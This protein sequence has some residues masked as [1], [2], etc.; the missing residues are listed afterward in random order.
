[1]VSSK[2]EK[3]SPGH[4][5]RAAR[6]SFLAAFFLLGLLACNALV[7]IDPPNRIDDTEG[8][9]TGGTEGGESCL[10]P[11]DCVD[12]G[13]NYVCLFR[14]CSPPCI[15]DVDCTSGFRC[16]K[17]E[18]GN[19]CVNAEQAACRV[20]D[21]AS[22]CPEGNVCSGGQCRID[23][24]E[25]E[26]A[27][28]TGQICTS[29][30]ICRG[31]DPDHDP[32]SG[33]GTTGEPCDAEG[34][35]ACEDFASTSR[36]ICENEVWTEHEPCEAG[37]FCNNASDP[38]GQCDEILAEC[39]GKQPIVPF[40]VENVRH[41]C[42][43]DLVTVE[44]VE[45]ESNQHCS[46]GSGAACAACL[47]NTFDCNGSK[48]LKCNDTNT[49]FIEERDCSTEDAPCSATAGDCTEFHC[50]EGQKK[51]NV[52]G[53]ILEVCSEDRSGFEEDENCGANR[54]DL[55]N[56]VCSPCP[57][58]APSAPQTTYACE[59]GSW[60]IAGCSGSYAHCDASL[61]N[62]CETN[63]NTSGSH[64]GGCGTT[65]NWANGTGSCVGGSCQFGSCN[66][67]HADCTGGLD[68]GCETNT[69]SNNSHCGGCGIACQTTGTS[70]NPCTGSVCNPICTGNFGNCDSVGTN[71]CE[72]LLN[73]STHCGSC[74]TSCT[75]GTPVCLNGSSCVQ[76]VNTGQCTAS[77][78]C[79][80]VICSSNTCVEDAKSFGVNCTG[81]IC[82]G[83]G[84]CSAVSIHGQL[85]PSASSVNVGVSEFTA[86]RIFVSQ[87]TRVSAFGI[88]LSSVGSA[89]GMRLGIYTNSSN[90]P[91]S[92]IVASPP[93]TPSAG[94][95]EYTLNSP[96]DLS[97]GDYWFVVLTNSGVSIRTLSSGTVTWLWASYAY[98]ALP[99]TAPILSGVST[100]PPDMYIK[101]IAP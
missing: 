53:D 63:T 64:C 4:F 59:D 81:G 84:S 33:P 79:Y 68:N 16:L 62:G 66:S 44:S 60:V 72:T 98:A 10:L 19:A 95:N 38:G 47:P 100:R 94:Q 97:A 88:E 82:N 28:L 85:G 99:T 2:H 51:C 39:E 27:C 71:G 46:Y 31:T 50:N 11:S 13:E 41:V 32:S 26:A 30:G 18:E 12:A 14:V 7:G 56:L 49:G 80:T 67:P 55:D 36:L 92:L 42:G 6:W 78:D 91:Q 43:A 65:C 3:R 25:N 29:S 83:S 96:I 24:S 1:M 52:A 101:G 23:C 89:T 37:T 86:V 40:C 21:E 75:G 20:D 9:G 22:R 70:S 5:L 57:L 35:I 54:C 93:F 73:T 15:G 34:E 90:A 8:D 17:T 61:E 77:N 74:G 45:C 87:A 76:C 48:L 58:P 69:S